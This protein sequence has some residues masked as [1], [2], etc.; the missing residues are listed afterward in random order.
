MVRSVLLTIVVTV[1]G[2]E[3]LGHVEED[4]Q[5]EDRKKVLEHPLPQSSS[6]VHGLAVVDRIVDSHVSGNQ[7][8]GRI[9]SRM[10]C[11]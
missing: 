1:G 3:E 8:L 4:G 9:C 10:Y 6:V 2:L 11:R 5:A 7:G